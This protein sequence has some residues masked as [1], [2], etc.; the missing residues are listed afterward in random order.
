MKT[1]HQIL[2]KIVISKVNS[3][4][5]CMRAVSF[6]KRS[7][8]S[9]YHKQCRKRAMRNSVLSHNQNR[10]TLISQWRR[11]KNKMGMRIN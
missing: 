5:T 3:N 9:K 1:Y 6:Y 4:K 7:Q 10:S 2:I 8:S 11:T